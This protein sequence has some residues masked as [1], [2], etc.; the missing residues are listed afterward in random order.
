MNG[1]RAITASPK[2]EC[3]QRS[4]IIIIIKVKTGFFFFLIFPSVSP[5]HPVIYTSSVINRAILPR[6]SD[7]IYSLNGGCG[8]K[9]SRCVAYVSFAFELEQTEECRLS[10]FP[11]SIRFFSHSAFNHIGYVLLLLLQKRSRGHFRLFNSFVNFDCH[12]HRKHYSNSE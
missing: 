6:L 2:N 11:F 4:F 7:S 10:N 5:C 1:I 12:M 3:V 9:K 8:G